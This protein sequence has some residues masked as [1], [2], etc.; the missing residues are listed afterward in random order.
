[1]S[2]A[3]R[4]AVLYPPSLKGEPE[5]KEVSDFDILTAVQQVAE[6][7]NFLNPYRA[8]MIRAIALICQLRVLM[9][10]QSGAVLAV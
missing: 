10:D 9:H 5:E 3:Y 1:M 6:T 8:S 7:W 4:P 2:D